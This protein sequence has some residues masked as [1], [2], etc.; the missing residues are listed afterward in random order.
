MNR[1]I[2]FLLISIGLTC[3]YLQAVPPL[4]IKTVD[5]A[6][7]YETK[8]LFYNLKKL[9]GRGIM[10]GHED[11]T[12]YGMGWRN[13][14]LRSDVKEVCGKF[15]AIYGWDIWGL[16]TPYNIDSVP[17]DRM[18]Q[19]IKIAYKRG[20]VHTVSWHLANPVT[21][22]HAWD[23]S[24]HAVKE[25]LPGGKY[26][27]VYNQMLDRVADFFLN[28]KTDDGTYIP[29]IFR[30]FHEHNG[31]WFWWGARFCTPDEYKALFR[32]TV[33]YLRDKRQVHNLLYAYSPDIFRK[34][35]VYLERFPGEEYVDVLGFDNYWDFQNPATIEKGIEQ[36]RIVVKLAERMGKVAALTEAGYN[37]IPDPQWWTKSLLYP[38]KNDSIA[39]KIA[40]ILV[41]RNYNQTHFFAPYP[42]HPSAADFIEFEKDPYTLF[43]SDLP[44]MYVIDNEKKTK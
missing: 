27:E 10:F 1:K 12:S 36:L 24:V 14:E 20:G 6:A 39:R 41:W 34:E 3:G 23:T 30:P 15:P 9:M 44:P 26:H 11:A 31:S 7:T 8:A 25:I 2:S 33:T 4:K 42:G 37:T 32:Y 28:L 16:G 22:T 13:A 21:Q 18:V 43:E 19:W 17:F 29:V 35:E 5:T 38:I 40:W